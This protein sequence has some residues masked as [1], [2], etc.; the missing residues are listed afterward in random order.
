MTQEIL[1]LHVFPNLPSRPRNAV[2]FDFE[3]G[4]G[5][6]SHLTCPNENAVPPSL[7]R[8]IVEADRC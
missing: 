1:K 4:N 5:T 2:E 7:R 3:E 8:L 6:V